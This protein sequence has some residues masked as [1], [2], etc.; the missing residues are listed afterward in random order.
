MRA[1]VCVGVGF[2]QRGVFE[3]L[4]EKGGRMCPWEN[5]CSDGMRQFHECHVDVEGIRWC[6]QEWLGN[7][8]YG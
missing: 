4:W 1:I 7:F 6:H 8:D 3:N 5:V 2:S